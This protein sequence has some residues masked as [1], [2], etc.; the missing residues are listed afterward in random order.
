LA[1][2]VEL[3]N[4]ECSQS[5]RIKLTDEKGQ[6]FVSIYPKVSGS[7]SDKEV[8][9]NPQKYEGRQTALESDLTADMLTVTLAATVGVNAS[10][11]FAKNSH[12]EKATALT[13]SVADEDDEENGSGGSNGSSGSSSSSGSQSQTSLTAPSISGTTPFTESTSVT[14]SGPSGAEIRYTT[15]GSTPTSSSSLYSSALSLSATTTVK[16]IAI[17]NG[18]SSEVTTKVFTKNSGSGDAD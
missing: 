11:Q 9:A 12:I 2:F 10:K 15:D 6:K 3:I 17:K 7:I 14:M 13:N 16:A 5:M 1:S 4:E 8:Q 18:Q